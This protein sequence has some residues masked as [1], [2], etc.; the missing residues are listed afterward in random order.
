MLRETGRVVG[1]EGD[2]VWVETLRQSACSS[3]A[4]RAGCGHGVVNAAIPG[5]SR[6]LVK[7]RLGATDAPALRLHDEVCIELP[8]RGFLRGAFALYALPI[9][10]TI[11]LAMAANW[12]LV[13]PGS[14]QGEADLRVMLGAA[15]G[16]GLGLVFL[17]RS[18]QFLETRR[19][20]QPIVT[21]KV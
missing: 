16:L 20:M 15:L 3:C 21:G 4:A 13:S 9:L 10:S 11:A 7:A 5:A 18:S 17:R 8:E 14:S 19:D 2:T 1:L 12:L 6:A